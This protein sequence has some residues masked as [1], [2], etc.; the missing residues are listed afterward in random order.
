MIA[1]TFALPAES[2]DFARRLPKLQNKGIQVFHTGVGADA[3][4]ARLPNFLREA[5]WELV[6]SAGFAGGMRD[7]L[8][9][10]DLFLAENF[11][12]PRL[13][14][15]AR[16]SLANRTPRVARLFTSSKVINSAAERASLAQTTDAAAVDMETEVIAKECKARG[17]PFLSLRVISDTPSQPL[18]AAPEVLF[19]M[20]R[21]Q[22]ELAKLALHLLRNPAA[23][24]RLLLFARRVGKARA[25]LAD[26]LIAV[27]QSD[28][29]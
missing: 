18:P 9:V 17:I 14:A 21:Q 13:L 1:V 25:R 5:T 20:E 3:C 7:D 10:G 24:P 6:I 4:R 2:S 12:D 28:N 26:A 15:W 11:S 27:L 23:V 19:N 22:T 8:R 16:Q 29:L